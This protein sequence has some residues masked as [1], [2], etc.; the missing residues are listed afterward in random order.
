MT[1]QEVREA[2]QAMNSFA[3]HLLRSMSRVD[4]ES[5]LTPAR[6]SALS[7]I[8]FGGPMP[9]GRLARAEGV[10]S[11]TMSRVV[12]ALCEQGLAERRAHDVN[13]RVTLVV[14]TSAG[15]A[16]MR[17]AAGRRADVIAEALAALPTRQRGSLVRATTHFPALVAGVRDAA[18]LSRTG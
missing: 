3:I 8:H 5:G 13:G 9:L 4:A 7:V 17:R 2:A 14:P 12:D 16:L 10:S 1:G 6:L 18:G 11:P 15:S